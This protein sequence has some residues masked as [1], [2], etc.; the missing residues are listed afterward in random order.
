MRLIKNLLLI[1][2]FLDI[3]LVY[4]VAFLSFLKL[5][6][7]TDFYQI[8]YPRVFEITDYESDIIFSNFKMVDP[9]WRTSKWKFHKFFQKIVF[10][11]FLEFLIWRPPYWIHHFEILKSDVEFIISDLENPWLPNS[12]KIGKNKEFKKT[13]ECNIKN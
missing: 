1:E 6:I 7:F 12:I 8:R 3:Y 11:G 4:Y 2:W 13:K 9:I 5:I 10:L